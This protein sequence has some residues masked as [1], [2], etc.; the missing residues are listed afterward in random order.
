MQASLPPAA[1]AALRLRGRVLARRHATPFEGLLLLVA[2]WIGWAAGGRLGPSAPGVV[3]AGLLLVGLAVAAAA[4]RGLGAAP[5]LIV[6]LPSGLAPRG[7]VAVRAAEALAGALVFA[8]PLGALA[9]GAT[10]PAARAPGCLAA[11]VAAAALGAGGLGL[12]AGL[13]LAALPASARRAALALAA[14]ALA[15]AVAG[16]AAAPSVALATV[17]AP[18]I[19]GARGVAGPP[20]LAALA[21]ASA[22]GLA[23]LA[24]PWALERAFDRAAGR[25]PTARGRWP[26]AV[27]ALLARPLGP[28]AASIAARDLARL[29]R[30]ASPRAW[31]AIVGAPLGAAVVLVAARGDRELSPGLLQLAGVLAAGVAAAASGFL[32]GVDLPR[33]TRPPL[34]VVRAAP[35]RGAAVGRARR[36][37]GGLHALLAVAGLG[38]VVALDPDPERAARAPAVLLGGALV[39]LLVV[40]DAVAHGL[41]TEASEDLAAAA[42]YP[43]RA[44][45]LV[46]LLGGAVSLHP[47]GV[48]AYP[49]LGYVGQARLSAVRWERSPFA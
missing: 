8:A 17:A 49:L 40:H 14:L 22:L 23:L 5:E 36:L 42:A 34:L 47:L 2:C 13:L 37:L 28:A 41:S 1:V 46:I 38:L 15:A 25:D 39:S 19:D 29:V 6:L 18:L 33:A 45:F 16:G 20:S 9:L 24:A 32:F 11:A 35:V 21:G 30:G 44:A 4:R 27:A 48:L 3:G 12:G 7:L 43:L 10:P 31:L 26:A